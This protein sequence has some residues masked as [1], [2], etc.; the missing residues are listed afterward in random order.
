[1]G[2]T[3][4]LVAFLVD[5]LGG[6]DSLGP[7]GLPRDWQVRAVRGFQTPQISAAASDS[8]AALKIHGTRQAAFFYR[9][10]APNLGPGRL[11]WSW[12]VDKAPDGATLARRDQDDSP[13]RVFVVFGKPDGRL[14]RSDHAIFYSFGGTEPASYSA[15]S[16]VSNRLHIIGLDGPGHLGEWRD[17]AVDPVED[18][19]RIWGKEPSAITAVGLM[20]DSDQTGQP[21]AALV[22]RLAWEMRQ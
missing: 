9:P 1:M 16:H 15:T 8:G 11:V 20:Q 12:R 18:F 6:L 4:T 7:S 2:W 22:R 19:R 17:H 13:I 21:A 10:V 5:F 14:R 3:T